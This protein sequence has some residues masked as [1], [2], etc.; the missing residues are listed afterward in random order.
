[1]KITSSD[2]R[3]SY[4]ILFLPDVIN[5]SLIKSPVSKTYYKRQG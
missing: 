4:S 3:N 1:M 2:F 5:V